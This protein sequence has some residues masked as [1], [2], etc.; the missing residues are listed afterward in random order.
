MLGGNYETSTVTF[1]LGQTVSLQGHTCCVAVV[2][3]LA[4]LSSERVRERERATNNDRMGDLA[5]CDRL[6]TYVLM[7][8]GTFH[9]AESIPTGTQR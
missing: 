9:A 8:M 6:Y 3:A 2:S 1:L 4:L 7:D 5:S